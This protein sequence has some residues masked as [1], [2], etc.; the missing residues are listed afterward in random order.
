MGPRKPKL[1]PIAK[2][3]IATGKALGKPHKAI[4][5]DAGVSRSTVDH[6]VNSTEIQVLI[7]ELQR[8]HAGLLDSLYQETIKS[9]RDD[10]KN[11]DPYARSKARRE[12][13]QILRAGERS[14]GPDSGPRLSHDTGGFSLTE[15]LVAVHTGSS[16]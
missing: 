8:R 1:T 7:L 3:R 9:C 13:I 14:A 6:Q 12:S 11:A 10:L 16:A 4:A 15:L 2:R 5:R